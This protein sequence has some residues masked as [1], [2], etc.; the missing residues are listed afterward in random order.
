MF[1]PSLP[2]P[3]RCYENNDDNYILN[4]NRKKNVFTVIRF[5][6]I[7]TAEEGIIFSSLYVLQSQLHCLSVCTSN[8]LLIFWSQ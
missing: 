4:K 7:S 6:F 1:N 8:I 5:N 2:L 3:R